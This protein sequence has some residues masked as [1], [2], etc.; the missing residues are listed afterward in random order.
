MSKN[1]LIRTKSNHILGPISREK[2]LELFKNHSIKPDD[3]LCSGNGFWF[4]VRED[5][6]LK[7]YLENQEVQGFNPIS[8]AKN[9][10]TVDLAQQ[11][12][13]LTA[14]H[15]DITRVGGLNLSLLHGSQT[16]DTAQHSLAQKT[17]AP[18]PA[19]K[20]V[21]SEA[22]RPTKQFKNQSYLQYLMI[23]GLSLIVLLVYF[24]KNL[25]RLLIDDAQAQE[26]VQ[27]KK[28]SF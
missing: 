11:Q 12:T 20:K 2:V 19:K 21:L 15:D 18:A 1:W 26:I 16:D 28:K 23:L 3:E 5:D 22:P 8:E 25:M 9:V 27:E 10:L 7:R 4:F 13:P 24:R 6:L 17:G 14:K